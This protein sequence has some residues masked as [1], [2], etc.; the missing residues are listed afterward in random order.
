MDGSKKERVSHLNSSIVYGV[1]TKILLDQRLAAQHL[2]DHR[3]V[4]QQL[5][6]KVDQQLV[7]QL[8][9]A[10]RPAAGRP[11]TANR[12]PRT[13]NWFGTAASRATHREPF[14]GRG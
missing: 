11:R 5:V 3:L 7:L 2:V 12:R 6:D 13:A 1:R 14:K 10:G 9:V 4:D 8:L